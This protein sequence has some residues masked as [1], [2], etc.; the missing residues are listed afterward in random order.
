LSPTIKIRNRLI[1]NEYK[2]FVIAELGIN[3]EGDVLKAKKMVK[4]AYYSGAECVKFQCHIIDDE[5]I[6]N[7]VIP[8]NATESI[9]N[10]MKRCSLTEDEEIILKNYTEKLGLI[11]LNTPITRKALNRLEE[12]GI[13]AYKIGSGECNNYP[14]IEHIVSFG[15]PIILSTGM[16]NLESISKSIEI[17]EKKGIDYAILHTTSIYPTPYEHT[18]LG[19]IEELK[20]NFPNAV[21]GLSDHSIRNYTCF[22]AVSLG[23]SILEKHF[24]SDKKWPGPDI[25]VSIDPIEL[26][27][28]I[29]GCNAIFKATGGHKDILPEEKPTINF[30]YASVVTIQE[31]QKDELFTKDNIWVKRPGDGEI[32]AESYDKILNQKATIDIKKDSQLDWSMISNE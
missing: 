12:M 30:A 24:T 5:M 14:L 15:K 20:T 3:H 16:N 23:A 32:K 9:W 29:Y 4:D 8:G 1:G 7:D 31:I 28:L 25:P 26:R 2:P 19:A 6:K 10:I 18:R 22:A 17:I 13:S 27:D 11:Y 21:I